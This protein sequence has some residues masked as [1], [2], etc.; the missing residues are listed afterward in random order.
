MSLRVL[1]AQVSPSVKRVAGVHQTFADPAPP[2]GARD[3]KPRGST[4]G[5]EPLG[6]PRYALGRAGFP[7]MLWLH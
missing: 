4:A 3:F 6:L 5:A 7:V 2:G 1:A